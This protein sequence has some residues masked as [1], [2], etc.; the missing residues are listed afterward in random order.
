[1]PGI[2]RKQNGSVPIIHGKQYEEMKKTIQKV[3]KGS[4]ILDENGKDL[5]LERKVLQWI[6]SI[7]HEEPATDYDR[8]IQDGSIL[9]KVMT[10]IVF[11]SVP[12]DTIDD[13]WGV[14]PALD[15]VKTVIREI[16]R[17]GVV[18]VFEPED[19]IELRNI[20]KVTKCL[21]QLSKLAAS[22]K[23]SLLNT[24]S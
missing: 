14:N 10:S 20:P 19:P 18:D 16:R 11:N 5:E 13:N 12:L 23:D 6:M 1:M 8:F 2:D 4:G 17:Y 24:M 15:R 7:V 21:A 3:G 9:S 22:D